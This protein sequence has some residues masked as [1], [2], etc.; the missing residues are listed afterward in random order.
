M[1]LG[2]FRTSI[3][4]S[5]LFR[6]LGVVVYR[7]TVRG[8]LGPQ[9]L[10]KLDVMRAES[11][12]TQSTYLAEIIDQADLYGLLDVLQGAGVELLSVAEVQPEG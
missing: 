11:V 6:T 7:V 9:T 12:G 8:R 4:T 10:A 3:H 2:D 5:G 1:S